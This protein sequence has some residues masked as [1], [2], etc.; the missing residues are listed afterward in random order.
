[1]AAWKV[2]KAKL[3]F[4]V[5][6]DSAIEQVKGSHSFRLFGSPTV[7]MIISHGSFLSY[8][9]YKHFEA[10]LQLHQAQL[11]VWDKTIPLVQPHGA[12]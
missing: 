3:I 1:M 2:K 6:S 7:L 10:W 11:L 5:G 9:L 12:L 4:D 8:N